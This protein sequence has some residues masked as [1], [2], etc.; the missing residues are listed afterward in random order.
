MKWFYFVKMTHRECHH[1][2]PIAHTKSTRSYFSFIL[3]WIVLVM[4][5][6]VHIVDS[7]AIAF[8][9]WLNVT[10]NWIEEKLKLIKIFE[11]QTTTQSTHALS[12]GNRLASARTPMHRQRMFFRCSK[13]GWIE[14]TPDNPF[15]WEEFRVWP[16]RLR[17]SYENQNSTKKVRFKF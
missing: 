12:S 11:F 5:S 2:H 1:H 6:P 17:L 4:Q 10:R 15:G 16:R 13:C 8:I 9:I 14:Y 3:E 7:Y